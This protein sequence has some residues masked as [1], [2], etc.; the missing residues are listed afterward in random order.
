M[1]ETSKSSLLLFCPFTYGGMFEYALHQGKALSRHFEVTF[2]C[3]DNIEPKQ[4]ETFSEYFRFLPLLPKDSPLSSDGRFRRAWRTLQKLLENYRILDQTIREQ[5][6]PSILFASFAEY[7]APLW[8]HRFRKLAKQEIQFGAVIHD[9][10]RDFQLGPGWWHRLSIREAYSFLHLAFVHE[11]LSL[12]TAGGH[13][14]KTVIVPHGP[15]PV[16][17]PTRKA[18][19]PPQEWGFPSD[20]PL[21]LS[22]GH[23]RDGKN[24]DLFIRAMKRFPDVHLLVAGKEQSS[25]QKPVAYYRRLARNAG[26][27]NRCRF[28]HRYIEKQEAS[29][30]FAASSVVLLTYSA[31]FHSASGVL[32]MVASFKKPVLASAGSGPLKTAV[33]SYSLGVWIEPDSLASLEEGIARILE[34]PREPSRWDRYLEDHSWETHAARVHSA[35]AS[36]P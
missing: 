6:F 23:I 5:A 7:F 13:P 16:P 25:A 28:L 1:E 20:A 29:D 18:N 36:R 34:P 10:V 17:A 32:N 30:L 31:Q 11:A 4:I 21:F 2:L 8:A 15:Y 24:L 22:F 33:L 3:P 35:F 19:H 12:D 9:P 27:E 14:P 26:V